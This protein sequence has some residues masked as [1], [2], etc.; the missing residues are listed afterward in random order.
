MRS[1]AL[2]VKELLR[3]FWLRRSAFDVNRTSVTQLVSRRE[4]GLRT[5]GSSRFRLATSPHRGLARLFYHTVI[6]IGNHKICRLCVRKTW[7]KSRVSGGLCGEFL[8][9]RIFFDS[10]RSLSALPSPLSSTSRDD[11]QPPRN[12]SFR[13]PPRSKVHVRQCSLVSHASGELSRPQGAKKNPPKHER[14]PLP[15]LGSDKT[16]DP[17]SFPFHPFP[18]PE[19]YTIALY[20][21]K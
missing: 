17:S 19:N 21:S 16:S 9:Y 14:G 12:C 15:L 7:E 5:I 1:I 4:T 6:I 11:H 20:S 8:I 18:S 10:S 2:A 13:A 3:S